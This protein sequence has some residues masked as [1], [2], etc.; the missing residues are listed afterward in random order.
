MTAHVKPI[1]SFQGESGAFSEKAAE[2][3]VPGP[4]TLVPCP[5][6]DAAVRM[7]V[8]GH[9]DFAAIPIHNITAGPVHAAVAAI[10]QFNSLEKVGEYA[11]MVRL[12]L[13]SI[14]GATVDGVREALSHEM[15]FKQCRR[16]LA[17]HPDIAVVEAHDTAGAARLVAIRRDPTVAA[18]AA[19]WAAKHYGLTI[20]A[21]GLEDRSDN[22]TTFV[23]LRR[24]SSIASSAPVQ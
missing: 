6:F 1:V 14:S 10:E 2:Q 16:F 8:D 17:S 15:A 18:I 12:A 13:M 7:V 20:L 23:L 22:A 24:K 9:A 19:P 3:L 21:E 4:I 11:L 5:T